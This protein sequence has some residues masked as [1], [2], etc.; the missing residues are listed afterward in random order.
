M[1]A[2]GQ[3][4]LRMENGSIN[5]GVVCASVFHLYAGYL[6]GRVT[7]PVRA[8]PIRVAPAAW[9]LHFSF[10]VFPLKTINIHTQK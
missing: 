5:T 6:W 3:L 8:G 10:L 9:F 1:T 2:T 4:T 7:Y